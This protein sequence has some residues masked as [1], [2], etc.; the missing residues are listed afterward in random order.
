M[1]TGNAD[2]A[3]GETCREGV[4]TQRARWNWSR[5]LLVCL[6]ALTGCQVA[7]AEESEA[8][9]A[10][11]RGIAAI[12]KQLAEQKACEKR[13]RTAAKAS[14]DAA[15]DYRK[16]AKACL[17]DEDKDR[18]DAIKTCKFTYEQDL[19]DCAKYKTSDAKNRCTDA[20]K[21]DKTTCLDGVDQCEFNCSSDLKDWE[22]RA[23]NTAAMAKAAA[24]RACGC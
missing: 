18:K 11:T 21:L 5:A 14:D 15:A 20:A 19:L 17:D 16:A 1:C 2:C 3:K 22:N 12:D 4:C 9:E 24:T 8:S 23:S 7:R 13:C 10:F 6:L